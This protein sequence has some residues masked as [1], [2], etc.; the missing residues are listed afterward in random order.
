MDGCFECHRKQDVAR[1]IPVEAHA[2]KRR[3]TSLVG[4]EHENELVDPR[5]LAFRRRFTVTVSA[6]SDV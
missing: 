2:V 1:L 5:P 3:A 6:A 4:A